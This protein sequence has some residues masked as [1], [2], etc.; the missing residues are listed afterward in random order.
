MTNKEAI[1]QLK[2]IKESLMNCGGCEGARQSLT[3]IHLAI[4]AL[5]ERPLDNVANAEETEDY[6]INQEE[7]CNIVCDILRDI[8]GI[9]IRKAK[10]HQGEWISRE[11][12][13]TL[14]PFWERYECSVCKAYGSCND[15]FCPNCG[16]DM[17]KGGAE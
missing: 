11:T 13:G 16:A 15:N 12:N 14:Y 9:D 7:N 8:T 10:K 6:I 2:I 17:R 5:E 4:K 3:C 1:E